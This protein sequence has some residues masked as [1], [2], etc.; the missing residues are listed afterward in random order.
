MGG[1][2]GADS[3]TK[4]ILP[5][6]RAALAGALITLFAAPALA[7][8]AEPGITPVGY[9]AGKAV[10]EASSIGSALTAPAGHKW[11]R[12]FFDWKQGERTGDDEYDSA[13]IHGIDARVAA[14]R[15]G[16]ARIVIT[17]QTLPTWA[18]E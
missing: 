8:A 7:S 17:V 10:D 15:A 13:F 5:R 12:L 6:L 16:G 14:L 2:R 3:E 18:P 4:M 11:V 1:S 9:T